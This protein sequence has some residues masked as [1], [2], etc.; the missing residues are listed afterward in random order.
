MY[1]FL[2]PDKNFLYLVNPFFLQSFPT[3][4]IIGELKIL[5]SYLDASGPMAFCYFLGNSVQS[6]LK[7]GIPSFDKSSFNFSFLFYKQLNTERCTAFWL[8]SFFRKIAV[9]VH[10]RVRENGGRIVNN[11]DRM[12]VIRRQKIENLILQNSQL[13]REL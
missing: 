1:H 2:G 5:N 13:F 10:N 11:V 6:R 12:R 7:K 3:S 8:N 4:R 9:N